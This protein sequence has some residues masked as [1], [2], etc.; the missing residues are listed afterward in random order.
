MA[1]K[2]DTKKSTKSTAASD[3]KS[4][5]FTAGKAPRARVQD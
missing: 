5:G 4:M 1:T 2:Q 3:G